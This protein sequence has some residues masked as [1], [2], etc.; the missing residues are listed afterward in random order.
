MP[1]TKHHAKNAK[2]GPLH[3]FFKDHFEKGN[4]FVP[5]ID[6]GLLLSDLKLVVKTWVD[7]PN[8]ASAVVKENIM[9]YQWKAVFQYPDLPKFEVFTECN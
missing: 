1:P 6:L 3:E 8:M 2:S 4:E 9:K 5:G 7:T